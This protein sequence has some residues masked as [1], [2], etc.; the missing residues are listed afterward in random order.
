[1]IIAAAPVSIVP[2]TVTTGT[3]APD[4]RPGPGPAA[5]GPAAGSGGG[6]DGGPGLQ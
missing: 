1:M 3:A 5:A 2:Q 6:S 4:R